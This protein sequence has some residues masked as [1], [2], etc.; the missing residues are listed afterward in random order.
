[1]IFSQSVKEIAKKSSENV[2]PKMSTAL[3]CTHDEKPLIQEWLRR[4]DA[5]RA[6]VS[7][8]KRDA[9]E[10]ET[11]AI[12]KEANCIASSALAITSTEARLARA[13]PEM[14]DF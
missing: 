11:L 13:H 6:L 1:M 9:R 3:Y 12:A 4:K 10:E 8:S 7:S 2:L 14:G 5:E